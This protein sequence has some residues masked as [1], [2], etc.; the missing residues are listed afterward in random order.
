MPK[1]I[2]LASSSPR[3]REL[4]EQIGLEFTIQESP[5]EED[6]SAKSDPYELA[7][8]LAFNK[9]QAVADNF[10]NAVVIGADTFIALEKE[11][12][13]KP[14]T[15]EKAKQ[16]LRK[17]SGRSIKIITGFALIDTAN[18]KVINDYGEA[19]AKIKN[20]SE[21]EIR[22]YVATGEPL[23][24]AGAYVAQER[25]AIFTER[26]EG[27]FSAIVGLPLNKIYCALNALE[28]DVLGGLT[29]EKK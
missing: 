26:I 21:K 3:R 7:K 22:D 18:D 8:F 4:L 5:Y 25:G 11:F 6:M 10:E 13:G 17:I 2:V 20:L 23:D 27:D 1:R 9:A 19:I 12:L 24:R 28:V 16:M 29:K 14:G 15:E